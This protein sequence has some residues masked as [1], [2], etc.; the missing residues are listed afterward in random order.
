MGCGPSRPTNKRPG[1]NLPTDCSGSYCELPMSDSSGVSLEFLQRSEVSTMLMNVETLKGYL[2]VQSNFTPATKYKEF[3]SKTI[4][5][6]N[7][8]GANI[9]EEQVL[10]LHTAG[11][12]EGS[13]L[14]TNLFIINLAIALNNVPSAMSRWY[15]N[16]VEM[17]YVKVTHTPAYTPAQINTEIDNWLTTNSPPVISGFTNQNGNSLLQNVINN[18]GNNMI[19]KKVSG[20]SDFKPYDGAFM[21]HRFNNGFHP[22]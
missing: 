3:Y 18:V 15:D 5:Y 22:F 4:E 8:N 14:L 12:L 21:K 16:Y 20:F 19:N 10:L 1:L 6:I 9:S 2:N 17:L 7:E 11:Q 13:K